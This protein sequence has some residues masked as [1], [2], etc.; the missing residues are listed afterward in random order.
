MYAGLLS[1]NASL[2]LRIATKLLSNILCDIYLGFHVHLKSFSLFTS[3]TLILFL[4]FSIVFPY[5][6]LVI[7]LYNAFSSPSFFSASHVFCVKLDI[8]F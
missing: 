8:W 2:L 5:I 3:F 7:N 4:T 6:A 1:F